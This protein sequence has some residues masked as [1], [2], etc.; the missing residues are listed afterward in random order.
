M[1]KLINTKG[2]KIVSII[3]GVNIIYEDDNIIL[4]DITCKK[5]ENSLTYGEVIDGYEC[6]INCRQLNK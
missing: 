6:C 4:S 3:N 5:C 2:T 1:E